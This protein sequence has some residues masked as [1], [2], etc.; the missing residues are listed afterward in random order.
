MYFKQCLSECNFYEMLGKVYE[1]L[2][3]KNKSEFIFH[4]FELW[5]GIFLGRKT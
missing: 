5:E 4:C 3:E 1:M 2:G